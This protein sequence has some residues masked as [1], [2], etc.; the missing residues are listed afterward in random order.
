MNKQIVIIDLKTFDIISDNEAAAVDADIAP[1]IIAL[2]KKGYNTMSSC[3][4]HFDFHKK[5]L[6]TDINMCF[7]EET[8]KDQEWQNE[9]I[10][11]DG[12]D[13]WSPWEKVLTI[14][15]LFAKEYHFDTLPNG[16]THN[17]QDAFENYPTRSY[18]ETK[19]ALIS[20]KGELRKENIIQSEMNEA[21]NNLTKWANELPEYN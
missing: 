6:S 4:G 19:I 17:V 9:E 5:Y 15:I 10:R 13:A 12:F 8:Q 20:E 3:S 7:L 14:Y 21:Y 16:F 1:A 2:N 11:N 18:I